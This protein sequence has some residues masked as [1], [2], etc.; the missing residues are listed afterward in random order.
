[1]PIFQL[2]NFSV[3]EAASLFIQE[4]L[5]IKSTEH[6]RSPPWVLLFSPVDGLLFFNKQSGD[7]QLTPPSAYTY[8]VEASTV[9]AL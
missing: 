5:A 2:G 1:M 9:I 3:S 4:L 6:P 7:A 8:P